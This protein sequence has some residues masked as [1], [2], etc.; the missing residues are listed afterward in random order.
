MGTLDQLG[1]RCYIPLAISTSMCV[2]VGNPISYFSSFSLRQTSWHW[3]QSSP[4]D[5]V[6]RSH[7]TKSYHRVRD[8][9]YA[10]G[11][12]SQS[13]QG[14]LP[15]IMVSSCLS[16]QISILLHQ[17]S[18]LHKEVPRFNQTSNLATFWNQLHVDIR[19]CCGIWQAALE[20][21]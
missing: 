8:H 3:L 15:C 10:D 11:T 2:V 4:F 19:I 17:G 14:I 9:F 12:Q 18:W 16:Y 5:P 21:P 20:L 13:Y 7:S 1:C 6:S